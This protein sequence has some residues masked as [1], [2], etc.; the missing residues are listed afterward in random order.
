M[1][2]VVELAQLLIAYDWVFVS[3]SFSF[4]VHGR[5]GV[6]KCGMGCPG[7]L[8]CIPLVRLALAWCLFLEC[9]CG[10]GRRT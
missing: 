2:L 3:S 6:L 10:S 5:V 7:M 1:C 9:S 8:L 4:L